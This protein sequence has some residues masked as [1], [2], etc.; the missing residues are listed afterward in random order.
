MHEIVAVKKRKKRRHG[1]IAPPTRKSEKRTS[2][3]KNDLEEG[4]NCEEKTYGIDELLQMNTSRIKSYH[5]GPMTCKIEHLT[6]AFLMYASVS[7]LVLLVN[8]STH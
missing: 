4:M 2:L 1:R 3:E 8:P 5:T 6:A 7:F